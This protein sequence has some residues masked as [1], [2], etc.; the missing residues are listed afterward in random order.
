VRVEFESGTVSFYFSFTFVSFGESCLLV[1]WCVCGRCGMACSNEDRGRSRRPGVEDQGWSHRLDTRW[2]GDREVGW[3]RV[4]P[5][6]CTW[7]RGVRVS[8][9][10][11]KTMVDG[12]ASK[13]LGQF[14]IDWGL[15]TDGDGL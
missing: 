7:R 1:S 9:L 10:S 14:L 5:A 13:P 11:L 3:C 12:L 15:K 2:P 8:W 6:P 4:R